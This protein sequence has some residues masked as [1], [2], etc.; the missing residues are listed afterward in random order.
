MSN[1]SEE[2]NPG[3]KILLVIQIICVYFSFLYLTY[4]IK[5]YEIKANFPL[6]SKQCGLSGYKNEYQLLMQ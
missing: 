5:Q 4:Y 2:S 6:E 1:N 3:N